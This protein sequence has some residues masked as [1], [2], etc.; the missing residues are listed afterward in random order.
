MRI[1]LLSQGEEPGVV[2][3]SAQSEETGASEVKVDATIDG[4]PL[5]VAFNVRFLRYVL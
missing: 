3:I 4:Q 1:N 2:E 5:L